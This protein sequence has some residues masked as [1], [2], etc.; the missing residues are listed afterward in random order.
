MNTIRL[1]IEKILSGDISSRE[2]LELEKRSLCGELGLDGFIR[3]SEILAQAKPQE[4]K[5]IL[6][7]LQKKPSR[8]MSGVAVVAAMTRP[9]ECP[10]GK[11]RYC[12]GGPEI[13][14]PQ[15]YTGKEPATRRAI[16]YCYDP[17]LQ[18]TFRL[19]QLRKIG[20]PIDKVDLIVMG[21]T[22]TAQMLDYQEWFVKESLRAMNEFEKNDSLI[23]GLGEEKFIEEY[24]SSKKTFRYVEDVQLE[25][26]TG[27]VRCIG[28]TFEPRPDW[29]KKEEINRM[30]G[31]G[32]TRVEVGVQVPDDKVYQKVNRGHT[33]AD[34]V[35]ATQQLKDSGLKV[36]YHLMPGILGD[37]PEFDLKMFKKVFEDERF[38]PDMIKIYPLI[39]LKGTEFYDEWKKG[40]FEPLTVDE[41]VKEIADLKELLPP[42][43]RTMRIMRDIPSNLVD[44]GIK[45]SNLG[46]LVYRELDRR[47]SKCNCIRCREVGRF[48]LKGEEPDPQKIKITIRDYKANGGEEVFLS[49]EDIKNDILIGFLRL[50][51]PGNPFRP[52]ITKGTGLVRELHVYG[53]MVELGEKP[54]YEWQHRGYGKELLEEAEK[55]AKEEWNSKEIL[56]T[57][58][59]GAKEYYK[60][61]GYKKKGVYMGKKLK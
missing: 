2:E 25:N 36:G 58:G 29:A 14:V 11:C 49:F 38:K 20:H 55:I 27:S 56:V 21:G 34:V 39:V 44:A 52:E 15:S 1:L 40:K 6:P 37:N 12:P 3:N 9:H 46:E 31:F 10:H 61:Q 47:K 51:K 45:S 7:L 13:N 59:I 30:L 54:E 48:I 5:R 22:L 24:K 16:Q 33:V 23:D 32:V 60:K 19:R 35:E 53:P 43:V 57:S 41:A 8:T 17:F 18:V 26:E 28:M 42:W 50:R 4:K